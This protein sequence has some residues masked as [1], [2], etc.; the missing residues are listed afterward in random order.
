MINSPFKPLSLPRPHPRGFTL[1]EILV[2]IS[3]I[4]ILSSMMFSVVPGIMNRVKISKTESTAINLRNAINAYYTEYR[5][6]PYHPKKGDKGTISLFTNTEL[7]DALCASPS[8]VIP[9]GLNP[10]GIVFFTGRNARAM[11]NGK[12]HNGV[13]IDARGGASL[14]DIWGEYFEIALDGDNNGRITT[15]TWDLGNSSSEITESILVWSN[16]PDKVVEGTKNDN[17][18]SW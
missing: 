15:P 17:V 18:T 14:Y 11:G 16:G 9:G 10:R 8:E 5:K 6:F 12:F 3:I 4:G 7:M 13:L 2:V 1:I